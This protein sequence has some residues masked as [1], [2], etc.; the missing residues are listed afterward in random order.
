LSSPR[1]S[2]AFVAVLFLQASHSSAAQATSARRGEI[3][4]RVTN[5][6]AKTP[7]ANAN[8]EVTVSGATTVVGRAVSTAEGGFRVSSL[9]LGA[10]YRV[11]IRALGYKPVEVVEVDLFSSAP[12]ADLGTIALTAAPTELE[13]VE[14]IVHRADI[15]LA[16]DRN[17]FVVRDM[18]T[19]RGGTALDVLRNVPAVDVDLDNIVSLRGNS[20]VTVQING[21]P[22]PLKPGPLGNFLSQLPADM[23]DKVEIIPNPSARDDPTGTA[24]VINIVMKQ[25]AD[26]GTSGGLTLSAGTTGQ[27]NTGVNLGYERGPWSSYGSYGFLRDRRPRTDSIFRA[28]N[29]LSPITYLD[30]T[31]RR[32]QKPLAHTLTGTTTYGFTDRDELSADVTY[33]TRNQDD[34]YGLTY[35][36][37]DNSRTLTALRDR[38]TSGQGTESSFESVLGLKHGFG[39][40]GHRLSAEASIVRDAEGGPNS[41]TSRNLTMSG[42]PMGRPAVETNTAWERPHE[43]NV[44]VDYIRPLAKLVRLE[45]GYKG[46]L[47][48]FH[49]TLDTRLFDTVSNVFLA[50]STRISNFTFSETVHA[51]YAMVSAQ[52]GKFQLQ[53]GLRGEL[54]SSSFHLAT[55]GGTYDRR[56]NSLFPSGLVAWNANEMY[57]V[58]LSYSTRIRR[59]D[60]GDQLDPTA[61]YADPLNLSRGNPYLK[62]EYTGALELGLQRT[63]ARVSV[64]VTPYWRRTTDAVRSIRTIDTAGVATR[65]YAN[66]ATADAYGGDA[67]IA[68]GGGPLTGFIGASGF[69]QVSNAANVTP[70]L[71][72]NT[73]GWRERANATM[74]FSKTFDVQALLSYTPPM[75]VEQGRNYSRTQFNLA[76]RKKLMDDQLAITL[77]VIDPFNTSREN[78]MTLDP[79]FVQFTSRA[80][81]VRGLL[82]GVNWMFGK[83]IKDDGDLV[84]GGP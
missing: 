60:E 10:R 84:S 24:G 58:K 70:G 17:T 31:G 47:Q 71:S 51:G 41:V 11:L 72:I 78:S 69:H 7:V 77:R 12:R 67:T 25:K 8:V 3:L 54:A 38:L 81:Q 65:T 52:R 66:I 2:A 82:L 80:R 50:D 20:G 45:T 9:A 30:E 73:W 59:P 63:G 64:Q 40:K 74:R 79:R 57:Q 68:L 34:S 16:P 21:R 76:G 13:A 22:S 48:E 83:P 46:S 32:V 61:H 5:A 56:Y 27:I 55:T 39:Q 26:A 28:N 19:T 4:G 43:N 42:S 37:L 6:T 1:R 75:T 23:V 18:P 33:S 29:Y 36:D 49:T 44:K 62:P 53:G 15:L 14:T 35:R